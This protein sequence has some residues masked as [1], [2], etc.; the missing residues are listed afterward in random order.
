MKNRRN[1]PPANAEVQPAKNWAYTDDDGCRWRTPDPGYSLKVQVGLYDAIELLAFAGNFFGS[2][3]ASGTVQ[4]L[5]DAL[6]KIADLR[7]DVL[8]FRV[9]VS[10]LS[11]WRAA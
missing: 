4:C 3:S 8:K 11:E 9:D 6:K 7:A 2:G 5:E 1:G 10:P